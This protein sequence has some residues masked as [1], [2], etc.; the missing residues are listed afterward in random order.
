MKTREIRLE[1]NCEH[2]DDFAQQIAQLAEAFVMINTLQMMADPELPCCLSCGDVRYEPPQPCGSPP[3]RRVLQPKRT[4]SSC[5]RIRDCRGIY[6][7]KR[8]TCLD[9]ACERAARLRLAGQEATVAIEFDDESKG[10]FHAY[11]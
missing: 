10:Q 3:Y 6:R 1:V 4:Q 7:N 8:G 2:D 11:V 9:L 5:Q